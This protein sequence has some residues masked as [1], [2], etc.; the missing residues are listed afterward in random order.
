MHVR[1]TSPL[2]VVEEGDG[3]V[4]RLLDPLTVEINGETWEV[5]AGFRTDFSSI[6]QVFRSIVP[7]LGRQNRASVLHDYLYVEK[8]VSRRTADAWFLAAMR[9]CGVS[10]LK[11][12]AVWAAVRIGGGRAWRT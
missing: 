9:A 8:P 11:R 5:P 10:W 7:V 1:F 4:W 2:K 3:T 6:P 12:N